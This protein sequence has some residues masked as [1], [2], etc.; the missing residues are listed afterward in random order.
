MTENR[1]NN[2]EITYEVRE[3]IAVLSTNQNGWSKEV[4]MVAWNGGAPKVDIR[5]WSPDHDRMSRGITLTK[6]EAE[7]FAVAI[8]MKMKERQSAVKQQ[9][10]NER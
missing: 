2:N 8:G 6:A 3:H 9:D 7:K 10:V 1:N 4:N 5:E